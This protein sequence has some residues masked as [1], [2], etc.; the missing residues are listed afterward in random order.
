M[1]SGRSRRPARRWPTASGRRRG[2]RPGCPTHVRPNF[3]GHLHSVG[4]ERRESCGSHTRWMSSAASRRRIRG[5]PG[6]ARERTG[7]PAGGGMRLV[8]IGA[9]TRETIWSTPALRDDAPKATGDRGLTVMALGCR[10]MRS[11]SAT[12]PTPAYAGWRPPRKATRRGNDA[13][14]PS[15][16]PSLAQSASEAVRGSEPSCSPTAGKC[17]RGS[18]PCIGRHSRALPARS[19]RHARSRKRVW[20]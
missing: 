16:S 18:E 17:R 15:Q 5:G 8:H 9:S 2:A 7:G 6:P 3:D 11:R 14:P 4:L 19:E 13:A 1:R 10:P 12:T 20:R